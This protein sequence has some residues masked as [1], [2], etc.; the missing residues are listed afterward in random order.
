MEGCGCG[1]ISD[2]DSEKQ[3]KPS[4]STAG[5]HAETSTRYLP[6][7]QSVQPVC[8]P[9]L[10]PGTSQTRNR[11]ANHWIAT[12]SVFLF[13]SWHILYIFSHLLIN[14]WNFFHDCGNKQ[15][16]ILLLLYNVHLLLT[17]QQQ[18]SQDVGLT[19]QVESRFVLKL[20]FK[21]IF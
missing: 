6:N 16:C 1:L 21:V 3:R 20:G 8:T 4:V 10:Q 12:L 14:M 11:R 7:P 17:S 18:V 2:R 15:L 9:R 5:V 19:R 13:F